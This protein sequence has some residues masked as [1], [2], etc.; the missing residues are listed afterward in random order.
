MEKQNLTQQKHAFTNQNKCTTILTTTTTI[1]QPFLWDHL[2]EPVLEENFWTLW[3]KGRLTGR[4]TNHPTVLHSIRTN[5]CPPSPSPPIF[6]QAR[7]PS[8]FQKNLYHFS[9]LPASFLYPH[10]RA[11]FPWLQPPH[12]TQN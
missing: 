8:A 10:P 6:L 11:F 7:C 3:C 9:R 5:Q 4:H 1:L 2:C 12:A